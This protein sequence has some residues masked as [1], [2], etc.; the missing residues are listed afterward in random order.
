VP[1]N[2]KVV[3]V[4]P[5]VLSKPLEEPFFF[6]QG[7]VERRS[8]MIVEVSTDEGVTGWGESLC[9]GL[10]P[11]E[12]AASFVEFCFKPMLLGRDPFD[13]EVLWEEMY[14]RTRPFGGGGAVNAMSGV[15]I[16]LWDVIGRYLERPIH[17]LLGGAF[18][19]E[20]TP[21]ATGFYRREG[22][23]HV[24]A[25]VEEARRHISEGFGA[26]KV[27]VGFGVEADVEYV[28]AIREAVGSETRLMMDANCAYD[29]P[30]ARRLLLESRDA[31]IHFFEEPLAP[32]DLEGYRSLRNL[33]S[34]Y[35]AAGENLFGKIGYRRWISEGA[36]DI[37]QPDLCSSGG[38]TECKKIAAIA[39]AWNTA[40][41]PHVWGSGIGLAASLQLIATLPPTPLSLQPEEPMLEYDRSSHPFRE[42][43]IGGAISVV[44]GMVPVPQGPGI[45]IE[46]DRGVLGRYGK[47]FR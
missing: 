38:F 30:A 6:S 43:L 31:E 8:T 4:V 29:V 17:K 26:M 40:V 44:D 42:D 23:N 3:D 25:G 28:H 5:H 10:Q 11:P 22:Q 32:E 13:V 46:V 27:K 7:W 34:T 14:N 47:P 41:V 45:G 15:D 24:E 2:V 33:S 9:H 39:Q 35:V 36:L 12:V 37:L 20:V 16:A 19:S 18:R 1:R 21:Y